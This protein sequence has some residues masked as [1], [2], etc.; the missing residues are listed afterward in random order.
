ME[1][2][3][4]SAPNDSGDTFQRYFEGHIPPG[5]FITAVLANDLI[6]AAGAAD[7]INQQLLFQY[8]QFLYWLPGQYREA[9]G[10]YEKVQKWLEGR[11]N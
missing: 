3:W 8:A 11:G 2:T 9:W 4:A 7:W 10:S 6:G 5:S 1:I